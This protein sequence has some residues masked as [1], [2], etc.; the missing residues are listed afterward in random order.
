MSTPTS[1]LSPEA[2]L[3]HQG[4]VQALARRLVLDPGAAGPQHIA[5]TN[6]LH[7]IVGQ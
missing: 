4:W 1:P 2:L 6:G 3:A 7:L 5:M